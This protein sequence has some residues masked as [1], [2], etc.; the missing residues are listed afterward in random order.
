MRHSRAGPLPRPRPSG[1]RCHGAGD[2]A[3]LTRSHSPLDLDRIRSKRREGK[4]VAEGSPR[5]RCSDPV[6]V[7]NHRRAEGCKAHPSQSRQ[8]RPLLRPDDRGAGNG[9]LGESDADVPHRRLR[10]LYPWRVADGWGA[11]DAAR[12]RSRTDA[13]PSRTGAR[14][15]RPQRAHDAPA[16]PGRT[17]DRVARPLVLAA[18]FARR[19][20][21]STRAD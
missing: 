9:C 14:L 20:A 10:A 16:H 18:R 1:C 12:F 15:D 19:R 8:Q 3:G 17:L 13:R 21:R 11:G 5:G 7:G 4:G 2:I 6:H